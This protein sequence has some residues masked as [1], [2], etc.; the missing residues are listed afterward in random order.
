MV[1]CAGMQ[2][3]R[4]ANA[5]AGKRCIVQAIKCTLQVNAQVGKWCTAQAKVSLRRQA[6]VALHKQA[7]CTAQAGKRC[8]AQASKSC[9]AQAG[10]VHCAGRQMHIAQAGNCAGK[11]LL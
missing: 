5:Q 10:M 9:F 2:L 7:W 8:I 11:H 1:H 4:Q 6:K 3:R